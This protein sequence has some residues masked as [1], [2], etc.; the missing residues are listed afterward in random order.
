MEWR[1]PYLAKITNIENL[2]QGKR[3]YK[4]LEIKPRKVR[5]APVK[6]C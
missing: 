3:L 1:R 4:I 5:K 2:K 6:H